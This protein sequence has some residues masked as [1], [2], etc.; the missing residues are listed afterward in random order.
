[1]H[2][3]RG[4]ENRPGNE[5]QRRC[6]KACWLIDQFCHLLQLYPPYYL[7]AFFFWVSPL[8]PS[9]LSLY[10]FSALSSSLFC[11]SYMQK[12]KSNDWKAVPTYFLFLFSFLFFSSFS[13]TAFLLDLSVMQEWKKETPSFFVFFSLLIPTSLM[14]FLVFLFSFFRALFSSPR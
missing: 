8:Q 12:N 7:L 3:V 2:D 9:S 13:S 10:W 1:M 6:L 5:G 4:E 14:F 11:R